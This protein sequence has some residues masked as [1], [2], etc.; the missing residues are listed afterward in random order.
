MAYVCYY[1][2]YIYIYIYL[3]VLFLMFL[4][5]HSLVVILAFYHLV[6]TYH[7]LYI[8]NFKWSMYFTIY[9]LL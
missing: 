7:D 4:N 8:P 1:I 6:Y 3:L 9:A 5:S 2:I